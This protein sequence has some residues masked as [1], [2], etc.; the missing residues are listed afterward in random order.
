MSPLSSS[1]LGGAEEME[2]D[3]STSRGLSPWAK[4]C[5]DT[6]DEGGA[7]GDPAS[8]SLSRHLVTAVDR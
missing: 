1:C 8:P 2:V 3:L 4:S 7:P 6:A 5:G